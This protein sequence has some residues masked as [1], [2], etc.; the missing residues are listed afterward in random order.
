MPISYI[1]CTLPTDFVAQALVVHASIICFLGLIGP[2]SVSSFDF[3]KGGR[4]YVRCTELILELHS[5]IIIMVDTVQPVQP[6]FAPCPLLGDQLE[7]FL[8]SQTQK[9]VTELWGAKLVRL[10][11]AL[12]L[13]WLYG[14]KKKIKCFK[15]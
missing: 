12:I 2:L 6:G 3:G 5:T 4:S 10:N 1:I 11:V 14:K 8:G 13:F 15:M 9:A 7:G